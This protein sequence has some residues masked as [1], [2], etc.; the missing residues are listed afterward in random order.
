MRSL[1]KAERQGKFRSDRRRVARDGYRP[2]FTRAV[3]ES[4]RPA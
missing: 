3:G 1:R 4:D 2:L